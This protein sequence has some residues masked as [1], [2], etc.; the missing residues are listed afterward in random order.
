MGKRKRQRNNTRD[1][2]Q[3]NSAPSNGAGRGRS[4]TLPAW[5]TRKGPSTASSVKVSPPRSGQARGIQ[6]SSVKGS[7]PRSGRGVQGLAS[8]PNPQGRGRGRSATLPAWMKS[9]SQDNSGNALP[10][11]STELRNE[12]GSPLSS[13]GKNANSRYEREPVYE[14]R[15]FSKKAR[16]NSDHPSQKQMNAAG[17]GVI[18]SPSYN[19]GR[20]GLGRGRVA[21]RPAWMNS[22]PFENGAAQTHHPLRDDVLTTKQRNFDRQTMPPIK[23]PTTTPSNGNRQQDTFNN[24][25]QYHPNSSGSQNLSMKELMGGGNNITKEV[26]DRAIQK[27][28]AFVEEIALLLTKRRAQKE[29]DE[30]GADLDVLEREIDSLVAE[31][32]RRFGFRGSNNPKKTQQQSPPKEKY[33]FPGLPHGW[34][35]VLDKQSGKTYYWNKNNGTTTWTRPTQSAY[36][37]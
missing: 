33:C 12:G 8:A 23:Q 9:K 37:N 13:A 16:F 29:I 3:N 10:K 11:R 19:R 2:F 17:R 4:S 25:N 27:R 15:N 14:N 24:T 20:R 22:Q 6:S 28:E 21:T 5:M 35:P 1:N 32:K 31:K 7:P 18:A 34:A 36:S 30:V 26:L